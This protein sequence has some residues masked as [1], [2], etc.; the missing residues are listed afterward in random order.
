MISLSWWGTKSQHML[1]P[2][3]SCHLTCQ[4]DTSSD[5]HYWNLAAVF[6]WTVRVTM[7]CIWFWWKLWYLCLFLISLLDKLHQICLRGPTVFHQWLLYGYL[8]RNIPKYFSVSV[9]WITLHGIGDNLFLCPFFLHVWWKNSFGKTYF[10]ICLIITK[11]GW[12]KH[13]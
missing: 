11:E 6:P 4:K 13:N 5:A 12:G 8:Y 7:S 10:R 9:W 3:L 1:D 2:K